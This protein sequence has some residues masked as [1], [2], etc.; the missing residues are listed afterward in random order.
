V[1][2]AP[3]RT[4]TPAPDSRYTT[5]SQIRDRDLRRSAGVLS[6]SA[7][8]VGLEVR[9]YQREKLGKVSDLLFDLPA[10]RLVAVVVSS[11][12]VLG[13]GDR[14][15]AV[16]PAAFHYD[17]AEKVLHL[18]ATKEAL[19]NA[20]QFDVAR[21]EELRNQPDTIVGYRGDRVFTSEPTRERANERDLTREPAK[22]AKPNNSAVNERDRAGKEVTPLDQGNNKS[23]T[24]TTAN[25]RK[26]VMAR[27]GLSVSAQNVKIIT[28]NGR[29]TLRGPVESED[30]RR[31][32]EELAVAATSAG[33]VDNQLEVKKP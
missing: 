10:G 21:W 6:R 23:D 29:V 20:P 28:S 8:I 26:A 30:E 2:P 33:S 18:E 9:N 13:V 3:D 7:D 22:P 27:D 25:I 4:V 15:I 5:P 14:Q 24:E 17:A 11:G 1:T 19:Q 16:D 12:G 31:I 32:I